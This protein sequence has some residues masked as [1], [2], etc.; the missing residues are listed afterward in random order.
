MVKKLKKLMS[1]CLGPLSG[2]IS[3]IAGNLWLCF[4]QFFLWTASQ[5]YYRVDVA[6]LL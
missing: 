2:F 6:V 5:P 1:E 4:S 3:A